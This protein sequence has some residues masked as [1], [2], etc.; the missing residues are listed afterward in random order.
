MTKTLIVYN[1]ARVEIPLFSFCRVLYD[2]I[3]DENL[4]FSIN[5]RDVD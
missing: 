4:Q 3:R 1:G 2:P 5:G